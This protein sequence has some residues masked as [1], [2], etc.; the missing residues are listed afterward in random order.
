MDKVYEKFYILDS[1]D[2]KNLSIFYTTIKQEKK[3]SRILKYMIYN[4]EELLYSTCELLSLKEITLSEE[5][6]LFIESMYFSRQNLKIN[7]LLMKAYLKLDSYLRAYERATYGIDYIESLKSINSIEKKYYYKLIIKVIEIEYKF[8]NFVQ[9]RYQLRKLINTSVECVFDFQEDII[10]WATILGIINEIFNN[11]NWINSI[12]NIQNVELK[13]I[14]NIWASIYKSKLTIKTYEIFKNILILDSRLKEVA[15][16]LN[17]YIKKCIKDNSWKDDLQKISPYRCYITLILN[18]EHMLEEKVDKNKIIDFMNKYYEYHSDIHQIVNIYSSL[19]YEQREKISS[20]ISIQFIGGANKIGGSCILVKYKNQNI[21][22]DAGANINESSYY[23]DFS[24]LEKLNLTLKDINYLVISHAHLDHTGSVPYIYNQNKYINIIC[25]HDTKN[26]MKVMLEDTARI[27]HKVDNMFS[28]SD[29]RNAMSVVKTLDFEKVYRVDD[30]ITITLYK[31]GH[32][33]GAACILLNIEGTNILY[34]GDYCLKNQ[35]TVGQMDLPKDLCVDILITETTYANSPTN[36]KLNRI[37][38]EKLLVESIKR[39]IDKDGIVLIPAFAVGRSQEI[40]LAIKNYYK[41]SPFIPFNVY[42][43]GKVVEICDIYQRS[44]K[45]NIFEKG[46]DIVNSKYKQENTD[47]LSKFKGSCI[48]ASSGMLNDGSSSSRYASK[49]IEDP[50]SSI[51]FSGYLDEESLGKQI[52]KSIQNEVV[53]TIVIDSN[54]KEVKCNVTSYKLSAHA[55][56]EEILKLLTSIKPKYV[57]LVHGDTNRNYKYL[58][59]EELGK[60]IYP[61]IEETTKYI[62]DLKIFKPENGQVFKI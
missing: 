26:I 38:Q 13:G 49:I 16:V 22:L 24:T 57:F 15:Q 19:V 60:V 34:T 9:A 28:A 5:D 7:Y 41:N 3:A 58:G 1:Y 45:I 30:N 53:P 31:A 52:L 6:L 42:V 25:T 32:I 23:P 59:N 17:M 21:L 39:S 50:N 2:K 62:K 20:D 55:T 43:D 18:Y 8:E 33:L 11:P 40:L 35:N 27:S 47:I 48:I 56:K 4:K 10:Y 12:K 61:G 29:I 14:V 44:S 36:F 46:I 51:F 54:I 37:N